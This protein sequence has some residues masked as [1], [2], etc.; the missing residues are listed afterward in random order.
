M[1]LFN[2][3]KPENQTWALHNFLTLRKNFTWIQIK[4]CMFLSN[5][6]CLFCGSIFSTVFMRWQLRERAYEFS[7]WMSCG[8]SNLIQS[9][10]VCFFCFSFFLAFL[11]ENICKLWKKV[12]NE[13]LL[14]LCRG[15]QSAYSHFFCVFHS[16]L[17]PHEFNVH[18]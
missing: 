3:P 8:A 5:F 13:F 1:T 14:W 10:C 6:M 17:V 15:N 18:M 12:W 9:I 11:S 16:L 2:K 7:S 4:R